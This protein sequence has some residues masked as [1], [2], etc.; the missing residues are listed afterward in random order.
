MA[1]ANAFKPN[2]GL[3]KRVRVT[4]KGK[5]KFARTG[6]GHLCSHKPAHRRRKLR[7]PGICPACEQKRVS[8]ML[9]LA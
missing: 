9:G 5:V 8:K 4:A 2:K 6:L 3:K 1:R 7:R